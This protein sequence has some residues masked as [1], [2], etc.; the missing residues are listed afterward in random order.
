MIK[1]ST[2]TRRISRG[3]PLVRTAA[4]AVFLG[5]A[6]HSGTASAF[7]L[8][9]NENVPPV[10][11]GPCVPGTDA[12]CGALIYMPNVGSQYTCKLTVSA[13]A[14]NGSAA[15]DDYLY[16]PS[17]PQATAFVPGNPPSNY[18]IWNHQA[19][20]TTVTYGVAPGTL[21]DFNL[22]RRVYNDAN[23][24]Y[25]A[26][27]FHMGK[28]DGTDGQPANPDGLPHA[29]VQVISQ[30]AVGGQYKV[31]WEDKMVADPGYP[32]PAIN[33]G[34]DWDYNDQIFDVTTYC[35]TQ[36]VGDQGCSLGFWKN[37]NQAWPAGYLTSDPLSKYFTFPAQLSSYATKT[38]Q[39]ALGFGGG[40]GV[41]GGAQNLLRQA[42]AA[43]LNAAHPNVNYPMTT[44]EVATAVNAALASVNRA[45]MLTLASE[46][47]GYNNLHGTPICQ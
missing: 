15:F 34:T 11:T 20:N 13:G 35:E 7:T 23:G 12:G 6:V 38:L 39:Q 40:P 8:D 32:R 1:V 14:N 3:I 28:G 21:L 22:Y 10:N 37:H 31:W 41:N 36:A 9:P 44:F 30:N 29:V 45:T 47:D 33:S 26:N 5:F 16:L 24:N 43:L 42:A 27:T 25:P 17:P 4:A 46:L 18:L 2:P 19:G